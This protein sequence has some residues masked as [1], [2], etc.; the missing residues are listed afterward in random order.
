MEASPKERAVRFRLMFWSLYAVSVVMKNIFATKTWRIG[1]LQAPAGYIFEPITFIAQDVEA[2]TRGYKSA[3]AMVWWGFA[4][5]LLVA[6]TA[7]IAIILPNAGAPE[8]Q[9]AF[10]IVLGNVPRILLASLTAYLVGGT[11]NVRIMTELKARGSRSLFTRVIVS[12]IF[13]QL[14]DNL[15]FSSIAFF[16]VMPYPGIL[17]MAVTM[18]LLETIYEII[19]FPITKWTIRK[20]RT[21]EQEAV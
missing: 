12:T 11:L 18:T 9:T 17:Y 5:N 3:R 21:L 14:V 16:G 20:I 6:V 10:E 19:F 13:G 1:F 4:L 7:W 2:E 15:L 8:V